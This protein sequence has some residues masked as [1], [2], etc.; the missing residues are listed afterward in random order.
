MYEGE[1]PIKLLSTM[2]KERR[3]DVSNVRREFLKPIRRTRWAGAAVDVQ[4]CFT[5]FFL[6]SRDDTRVLFHKNAVQV[7]LS[8]FVKAT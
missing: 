8:S 4:P 6:Y 7:L 3:I 1:S 5:S 2:K